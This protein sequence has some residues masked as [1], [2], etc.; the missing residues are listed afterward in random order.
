MSMIEFVATL[1]MLAIYLTKIDFV[2]QANWHK[3]ELHFSAF[4]VLVYVLISSLVIGDYSEL[5][6]VAGVSSQNQLC[7]RI[8]KFINGVFFHFRFSDILQ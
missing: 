4:G 2:L 8:K 7:K 3:I 5:L 1:I 6:T